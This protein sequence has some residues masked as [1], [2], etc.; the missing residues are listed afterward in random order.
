[1]IVSSFL[2][3]T[4][5]RDGYSFPIKCNRY[6][7]LLCASLLVLRCTGDVLLLSHAGFHCFSVAC[8]VGISETI[9]FQRLGSSDSSKHE[10]RRKLEQGVRLGTDRIKTNQ[11]RS[12]RALHSNDAD[13]AECIGAQACVMDFMPQTFLTVH[14]GLCPYQNQEQPVG[15]EIDPHRPGRHVPYVHFC[16][17]G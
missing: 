13:Q 15:Q 12:T 5:S 6:L 4:V 16:E 8:F 11:T 9:V 14:R 7:S 3:F 2:P 10:G 1:M 17:I